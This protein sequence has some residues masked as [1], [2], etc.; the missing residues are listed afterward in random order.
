MLIEHKQIKLPPKPSRVVLIQLILDEQ[1]NIPQLTLYQMQ[2]H[3]LLLL[4]SLINQHSGMNH[5][6]LW[7]V[8]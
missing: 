7:H 4:Q 1:E 5:Q 8:F 3:T 6:L 2:I